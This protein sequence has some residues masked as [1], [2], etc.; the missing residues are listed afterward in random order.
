MIEPQLIEE[1]NSYNY[2][3]HFSV[4]KIQKENRGKCL[5]K[6]RKFEQVKSDFEVLIFKKTKIKR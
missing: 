1:T 3:V 6:I 2:F 4:V 5:K